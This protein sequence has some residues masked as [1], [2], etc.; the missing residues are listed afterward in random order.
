MGKGDVTSASV[1]YM[2]LLFLWSNMLKIIELKAELLKKSQEFKAERSKGRN[3]VETGPN[4]TAG[5]WLRRKYLTKESSQVTKAAEKVSAKDQRGIVD[6][7]WERS[8][9]IMEEKAKI[10]EKLQ[11]GLEGAEEVS[12]ELRENLLVDF[13]R[14][15][16]EDR[17]AGRIHVSEKEVEVEEDLVEITD[18][19]GR[20]RT[21]PRSEYLQ[22]Q[23]QSAQDLISTI[24]RQIVE[25]LQEQEEEE[26]VHYDDTI[27]VRTKGVGYYRL[28]RTEAERSRQLAELNCLRQETVEARTRSM[29]LRE[30]R[31]LAR[32]A[33]LQKVKE[34]R[35][36]NK[37]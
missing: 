10:Y 24:R 21:I 3:V 8:R 33:R 37:L 5:S 23:E 22:Q 4:Q 19:F 34:R 16:H 31:Q 9:A 11:A 14:K 2:Y 1:L 35:D 12:A 20:T 17:K 15:F 25:D 28:S 18:E 6:E 30:K 13:D 29:I 26:N 27:E 7:Q 32:E 36:R